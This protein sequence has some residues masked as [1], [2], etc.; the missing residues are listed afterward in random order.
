MPR[1]YCHIQQ[2]EKLIQD[3][4]GVELPSLDAARMEAFDGIRDILAAGIR[5]GD[6]DALDDVL[7]ITDE[8]GRELMTI[9]FTEALPPR[10]RRP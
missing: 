10:L 2:G 5:R 4:N 9:P 3:P 6:D 7:I 8:T 1:Y